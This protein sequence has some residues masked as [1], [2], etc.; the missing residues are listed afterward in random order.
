[1]ELAVRG[2]ALDTV[3]PGTEE[4]SLSRDLGCTDTP[5]VQERVPEYFQVAAGGGCVTSGWESIT[6]MCLCHTPFHLQSTFPHSNSLHLHDTQVRWAGWCHFL[7]FM[8]ERGMYVTHQGHTIKV[9]QGRGGCEPRCQCPCHC[10]TQHRWV[11]IFTFG[12]SLWSRKCGCSW[13]SGGHAWKGPHK[14]E[15]WTELGVKCLPSGE[16]GSSCRLRFRMA[17][18]R[19][20]E[21]GRLEVEEGP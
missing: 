9:T 19:I 6:T 4:A 2:C 12:G 18:G 1:M 16:M 21:Q 8:A 17:R 15:G 10:L 3:Q 14:Q 5:G 20:L 13:R 11:G 7:H